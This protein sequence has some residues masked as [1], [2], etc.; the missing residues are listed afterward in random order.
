MRAGAVGTGQPGTASSP[1]RSAAPK[2]GHTG[3]GALP[4]LLPSSF[5]LKQM[6]TERDSLHSE[7]HCLPAKN[8]E[9]VRLERRMQ[10]PPTPS[11]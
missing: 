9:D 1:R 7:E 4:H 6:N 11:F 5:S 8:C 2:L 3:V 10:L